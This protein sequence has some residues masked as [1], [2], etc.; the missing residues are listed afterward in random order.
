[1]Q[2]LAPEILDAYA[3]GLLT[4]AE[5]AVADAHLAVCD[6]C[7]LALVSLAQM[8][9]LLREQTPVAPPP[10]LAATIIGQ[11]EPTLP[12][13]EPAPTPVTPNWP[14]LLWN[15]L[16]AAAAWLLLIILGGETV[17][18]AY[19][20]GLGDLAWLFQSQPDL[21]SAYPAEAFYAVLEAVPVIELSLTLAVLV[22]AIW[23]MQR[24]VATLP[25]GSRA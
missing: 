3:E 20:S 14:R 1:M 23:L 15:G 13:L 16:E 4:P 8:G 22:L 19:R 24:F 6:R 25:L 2:H 7:R 5:R 21:L 9:D 11:L 18:A 17:L 10:G 12:V